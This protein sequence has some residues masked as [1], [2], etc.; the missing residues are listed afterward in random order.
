MAGR[1]GA[2]L[3]PSTA[4]SIRATML[5][6]KS[7]LIG[8]RPM[9]GARA[10][11]RPSAVAASAFGSNIGTRETGGRRTQTRRFPSSSV[12]HADSGCPPRDGPRLTTPATPAT[13]A[14]LGWTDGRMDGW[15]DGR[16][17][18]WTDGRMDGWMKGEVS[19]AQSVCS[20]PARRM[21][22]PCPPCSGCPGHIAGMMSIFG[23]SWALAPERRR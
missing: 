13:P 20:R 22:G 19:D 9:S 12:V 16:M 14:T 6:S 3:T 5:P 15:T 18:G 10:L 4:P 11:A 17:D 1:R 2:C 23:S 8:S 21:T 7:H